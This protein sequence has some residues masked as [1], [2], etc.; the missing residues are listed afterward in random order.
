MIAVLFY[1]W[2][3]AADIHQLGNDIE[4]LKFF[5]HD[6]FVLYRF[7]LDAAR[8]NHAGVWNC[9]RYAFL[10]KGKDG[11]RNFSLEDIINNNGWKN[12]MEDS[13]SK[14]RSPINYHSYL[15]HL[16]SETENIII[17]LKKEYPEID[18]VFGRL[19]HNYLA[20]CKV[21]FEELINESQAR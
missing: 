15:D 18:I 12:K 17:M 16:D 7:L 5:C 1:A 19:S 21:T 4:K 9:I 20:S 13:R 6:I 2:H 10:V 8:T 11:C 3:E 14:N